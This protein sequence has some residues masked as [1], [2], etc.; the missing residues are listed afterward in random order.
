MYQTSLHIRVRYSE[1][2]QM[3]YVYYG[4]YA[5]YYEV[6][7]VEALRRL[8]LSYKAM[9]EK[10]IRMPVRRLNIQYK[11]PAAYDDLLRIEVTIPVLP[12]S[13]IVFEYR[14]FNE[15]DQCLNEGST[16]LVFLR[17]GVLGRVP[18][19]IVAALKPYFT[20]KTTT[21]SQS[22]TL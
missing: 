18:S 16:E 4:H 19:F 11:A 1:T 15:T 5:A 2:D 17:K 3:G 13:R 21:L 6:A 22:N 9:E 8:G 7:R 14:S 20:Q 10:G 12:Q